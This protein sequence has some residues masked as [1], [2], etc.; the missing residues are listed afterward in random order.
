MVDPAHELER[1]EGL[2][3]QGGAIGQQASPIETQQIHGPP[4]VRIA[5]GGD[6]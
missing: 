5:V 4:S 3:P 1:A 6:R 2:L